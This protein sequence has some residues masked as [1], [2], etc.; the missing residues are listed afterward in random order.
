MCLADPPPTSY[1]ILNDWKSSNETGPKIGP[2]LFSWNNSIEYSQKLTK[3]D[4][5]TFKV[6]RSCSVVFNGQM[7]LFGGFYNPTRYGKITGCGIE[8]IGKG[9]PKLGVKFGPS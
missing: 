8:N 3:F 4:H 6:D 5:G 9:I 1:L 2:F 7:M